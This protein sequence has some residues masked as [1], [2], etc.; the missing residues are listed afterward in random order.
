LLRLGERDWGARVLAFPLAGSP[1]H[2]S[3]RRVVI[4]KAF[5]N[6]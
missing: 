2:Q 3:I 4:A 6:Q 1:S 5:R